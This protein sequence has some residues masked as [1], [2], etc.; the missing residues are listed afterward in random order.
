M[1]I[2]LPMPCCHSENQLWWPPLYVSIHAQSPTD[3]AAI[4]VYPV[5]Q[6]PKWFKENKVVL[7]KLK[8]STFM[9]TVIMNACIWHSESSTVAH[10]CMLYHTQ[11]EMNRP[12]LWRVR[13]QKSEEMKSPF[14]CN[15]HWSTKVT[16]PWQKGV[17]F[18]TECSWGECS[19]NEFSRGKYLCI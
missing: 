4:V 17:T 14:I 15:V 5:L 13:Y 18:V 11:D 6:R 3:S 7:S 9:K 1:K 8:T 19:Y 12:Q 16:D 10:W 2:L